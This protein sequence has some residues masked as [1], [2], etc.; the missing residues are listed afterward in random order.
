MGLHNRM[1][2]FEA[3]EALGVSI[4][5]VQ[6]WMEKGILQGTKTPGGHRRLDP[7]AVQALAA[8]RLRDK[9]FGNNAACKILVIED[10]LDI[11]RLYEMM[12][13]SWQI[14]TS[15]H[16]EHDG[17]Q[18]LIAMGELQPNFVIVDLN[19]PLI[20]GFQLIRTL[21]EKFAAATF[22]Y[23]VVSA[24]PPSEI[25]QRGSLPVGC[26]VLA[27]PI[28]FK[29]LEKLITNAYASTAAQHT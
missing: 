25:A 7:D 14:P 11:C 12:S 19:I 18:G 3:A 20:D 5:T 29:A 10:D 13:R 4:R 9:N 27:K 28:D 15:L 22:H 21:D 23:C 24:L 8:K 2:T 1:S 6:Q 17:L 26:P 16:F